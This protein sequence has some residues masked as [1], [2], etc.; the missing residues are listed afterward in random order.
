MKA[1]SIAV[2]AIL[3]TG[4]IYASE[5]TWVDEQIEAIKPQR[6]GVEFADIKNP[7]IFLKHKDEIRGTK[8]TSRGSK[9]SSLKRSSSVV[10][11]ARPQMSASGFNLSTIINSSALI[12]GVWYKKNDRISGYKVVEVTKTSVTL[13]QGDRSISLSTAIKKRN[14]KFKNK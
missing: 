11:D 4:T 14:I 3:F 7:F 9:K 8:A 6:K 13:S 5:L 10:Y 12:N 1:V 2:M